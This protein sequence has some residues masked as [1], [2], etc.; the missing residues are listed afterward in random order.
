MSRSVGHR[1]SLDPVWLWLWHRSAAVA[2]IGPLAWEPPYA[3]DVALKRKKNIYIYIHTH[4]HVYV[5][6]A[7]AALDTHTFIGFCL[8]FS[9]TGLAL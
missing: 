8:K 4:T 9:N 6:A 3:A 5:V 1:H 2:L 7:A